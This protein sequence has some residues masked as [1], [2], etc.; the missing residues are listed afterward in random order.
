M[1]TKKDNTRKW[2]IATIILAV[3]ASISV[4]TLGWQLRQPIIRQITGK[5]V[6]LD[7]ARSPNPGKESQADLIKYV[8][9]K[10]AIMGI[11]IVK[12]DFKLNTRS[13]TFRYYKDEAVTQAWNDFI[14]R[15]V[16]VDL[17][18]KNELI[19]Q[20][21][22]NLINGQFSCAPVEETS[23]GMVIPTIREHATTVC[24]APIPPGYGDFIGFINV[25]LRQPPSL[26][27]IKDVETETRKLSLDM[28]ERDIVKSNKKFDMFKM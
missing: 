14:A 28:Y 21:I 26:A 18:G 1:S 20:R 6:N 19:N 7:N 24:L 15:N 16:Q 22:V 8:N 12:V 2:K 27:D 17:F 23:A 5:K 4:A 10:N 13:T 25:F 3:V 11:N 9:S